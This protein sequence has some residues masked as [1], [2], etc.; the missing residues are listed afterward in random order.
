MTKELLFFFFFFFS[1]IFSVSEPKN[2]PPPPKPHQALLWISFSFFPLTKASHL[3]KLRVNVGWG[4]VFY[5]GVDTGR[6]GSLGAAAQPPP[7]PAHNAVALSD[8]LWKM[9]S[10]GL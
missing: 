9:R 1:L 2:K 10:R 8:T 6:N 4:T 5:K 3:V 7:A